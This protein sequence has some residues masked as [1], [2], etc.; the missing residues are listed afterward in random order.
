M[1]PEAIRHW[2]RYFEQVTLTY[3]ASEIGGGGT[4]TLTEIDDDA[5]IAYT[6]MPGTT[7]EIVGDDGRP[8]P[9][10][11][12]G[13]VRLRTP[14]MAAGYIGDPEATAE[15]FRDGWFYPGDIGMLTPDGRLKILGRVK[16]LFNLGGVKINAADVDLAARSVRGIVD[17]MCFTTPTETGLQ[18]LSICAVKDGDRDAVAAAVAIRAAC[19]ARVRRRL[20]ISAIHFVEALPLNETGK[21]VRSEGPRTTAGLPVF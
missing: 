16:D 15:M 9:H 19:R 13:S 10:S 3:G 20:Q 7:A 1:T 2:L 11:V 5:E 18:Q 8:C 6:I 14:T 12:P 4:M 21:P 17:A